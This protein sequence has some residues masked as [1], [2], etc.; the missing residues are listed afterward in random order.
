MRFV[1]IAGDV[2]RSCSCTFIYILQ[3]RFAS[4]CWQKGVNVQRRLAT[5]ISQPNQRCNAIRACNMCINPLE[6]SSSLSHSPLPSLMTKCNRRQHLLQASEKSHSDETMQ[7]I[8][9]LLNLSSLHVIKVFRERR[10]VGHLHIISC[11]SI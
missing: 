3:L 7:Q 5:P 4:F 10:L 2:L 8:L 1:L 11:R 9:R 6:P